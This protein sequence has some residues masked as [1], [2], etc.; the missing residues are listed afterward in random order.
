MVASFHWLSHAALPLLCLPLDNS[1]SSRCFLISSSLSLANF[2]SIHCMQYSFWYSWV[3]LTCHTSKSS[4]VVL[5]FELLVS[6]FEP[7]SS[8]ILYD[9]S[10]VMD[11][12]CPGSLN[13]LN[14]TR[15]PLPKVGPLLAC[16][17]TA[18]SYSLTGTCNWS[19][20]LK[21]KAYLS[22]INWFYSRLFH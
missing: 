8:G 3:N 22:L 13:L 21:M 2:L 18:R 5:Y 20:K 12:K 10:S 11:L 14:T 4:S 15:S 1:H 7:L 9:N 6:I 17:A 19:S 16:P